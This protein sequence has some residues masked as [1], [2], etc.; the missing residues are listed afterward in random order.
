MEPAFQRDLLAASRLVREAG[1]LD[2]V[3]RLMDT[4]CRLKAAYDM[5]FVGFDIGPEAAL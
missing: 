5:A 1:E 4:M 2:L 3:E